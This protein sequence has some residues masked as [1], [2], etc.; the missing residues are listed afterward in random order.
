VRG[1]TGSGKAGRAPNGSVSE[2]LNE[3]FEG[4]CA[5]CDYSTLEVRNFAALQIARLLEKKIEIK[6]NRTPDEW[7]AIR[8]EVQQRLRLAAL[9]FGKG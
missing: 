8:K 2:Q 6:P 7:V 1:S 4:P 5:G 9:K 3:Q